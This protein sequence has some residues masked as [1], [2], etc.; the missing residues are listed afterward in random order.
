MF[1]DVPC[2]TGT[3]ESGWDFL[4]FYTHPLSRISCNINEW[5][6]GLVTF[7]VCELENGHVQLI[8]PFKMVV[9]QFAICQF[10]REYTFCCE[11]SSPVRPLRIPG[12][13]NGIRPVNMD[14]E[15]YDMPQCI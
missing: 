7:T 12:A 11:F 15:Y 4:N 13:E 14:Y 2:L 1:H 6:P 5:Q 8:Y 9:F 3:C 10:T